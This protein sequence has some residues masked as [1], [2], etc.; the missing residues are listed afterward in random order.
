MRKYLCRANVANAAASWVEVGR[1]VGTKS[2][3]NGLWES[4][5]FSE[6]YDHSFRGEPNNSGLEKKSYL[7]RNVLQGL[8]NYLVQHTRAIGGIGDKS[9]DIGEDI[10]G[11]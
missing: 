3:E 8:H 6:A 7:V 1:P 5:T 10:V 9:M 4:G 11:N 2:E